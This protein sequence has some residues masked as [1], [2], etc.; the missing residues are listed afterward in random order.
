MP[1]YSSTWSPIIPLSVPLSVKTSAA[2]APSSVLAPPHPPSAG[3]GRRWLPC[4]ALSMLHSPN[5]TAAGLTVAG[6]DIHPLHHADILMV[7]GVAVR[8]KTSNRL[9]CKINSKGDRRVLIIIDIWLSEI[10]ADGLR[11]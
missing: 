9:G 4:S 10:R 1:R 6:K 3:P 2:S 7:Y 5:Y 8:N 11:H